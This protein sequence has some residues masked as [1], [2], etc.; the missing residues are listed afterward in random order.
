VVSERFARVSGNLD[1]EGTLALTQPLVM[2]LQLEQGAFASAGGKLR[3]VAASPV[4][5]GPHQ[6]QRLS[7]S[8]GF[9]PEEISFYAAY[10]GGIRSG[11]SGR[12]V[13]ELIHDAR[14]RFSRTPP[15]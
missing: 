4:K 2:P 1:L 15:A 3:D 5:I 11:F 14:G 10:R 13:R 9:C 7:R 8:V 6:R 12:R